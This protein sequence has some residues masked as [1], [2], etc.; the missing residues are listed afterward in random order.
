[1]TNSSSLLTGYQSDYPWMALQSYLALLYG[2]R[3]VELGLLVIIVV[4]NIERN[5]TGIRLT[6][7][8]I[9]AMRELLLQQSLE[10]LSVSV[11][12]Y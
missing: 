5:K 12:S 10:Q 6:F 1:M 11:S 3:H 2:C 7:Y 4:L 8:F 9:V